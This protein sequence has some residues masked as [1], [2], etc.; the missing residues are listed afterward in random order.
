MQEKSQSSEVTVTGGVAPS[1][2]RRAFEIVLSIVI[3]V[4]LLIAFAMGLL[5]W[6]F[7]AAS[8]AGALAEPGAVDITSFIAILV[9]LFILF[10]FMGP[11]AHQAAEVFESFL[12]APMQLLSFTRIIAFLLLVQ[13]V[14][15]TY[16]SIYLLRRRRLVF[17]A[18]IAII[19]L[20][21]FSS[22]G[23]GVYIYIYMDEYIDAIIEMQTDD[24]NSEQ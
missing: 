18:F 23:R 4:Q 6:Q 19:P 2:R 9:V 17:A 3:V 22:I 12:V 10:A 21:I 14:F 8:A 15:Q 1:S 13:I 5:F 24:L 7:S 20:L 16:Y 11:T